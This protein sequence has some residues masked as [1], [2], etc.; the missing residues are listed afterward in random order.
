[1]VAK[2]D[3]TPAQTEKTTHHGIGLS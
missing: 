3:K 1:M 2:S